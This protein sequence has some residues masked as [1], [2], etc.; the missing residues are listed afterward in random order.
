MEIINIVLANFSPEVAE[1]FADLLNYIFINKRASESCSQVKIA[2]FPRMADITVKAIMEADFILI[3]PVY[4][5]DEVDT[6]MIRSIQQIKKN[7]AIFI[8][9]TTSDDYGKTGNVLLKSL[10]I[11]QIIRLPVSAEAFEAVLLGQQEI[12]GLRRN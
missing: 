4:P 7:E 12:V 11:K 5:D 8:V 1:A 3:D 10:G 9:C 2:N 6:V